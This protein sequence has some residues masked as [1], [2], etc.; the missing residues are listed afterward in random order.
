MQIYSGALNVNEIL[1]SWYIQ[2]CDGKSGALVSF[3]GIVRDEGGISGLS[4][5]IYEPILKAWFKGW[6]ER[7]K[8]SGAQMFFAH[9]TGD[10]LIGQSSYLAAV[11]SP[12]RRVALEMIDEFVEDFK[13]AAPIWKYDIINGER[14][15]AATRS[16]ALKSAGILAKDSK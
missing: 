1:N 9:S 6:Q 11:K 14:I 4:F 16:K 13:A 15:Y 7:A 5:E 3:V 8:I 10:V 2:S 12:K